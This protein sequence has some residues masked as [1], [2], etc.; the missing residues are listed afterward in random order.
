MYTKTGSEFEA[1]YA[2]RGGE[3]ASVIRSDD[4]PQ[5]FNFHEERKTELNQERI[6]AEGIFTGKVMMID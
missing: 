2:E 6:G 5:A 3:L 1:L 4:K